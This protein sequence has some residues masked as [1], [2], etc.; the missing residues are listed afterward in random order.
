MIVLMAGFPGTGKSTLARE[1]ASRVSGRVLSK[2]EI[3]HAV[4]R[5]EEIEY[6]SR[7]DDYCMTLMLATAGYLLSR[8]PVRGIFLDGRSFSRRYRC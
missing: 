6:S 8:N 5:P 7:Q 1:L 2:D 3:R 4:F